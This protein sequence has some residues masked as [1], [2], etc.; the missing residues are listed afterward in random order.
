MFRR[1]QGELTVC[2]EFDKQL[3]IFGA[4]APLHWKNNAART[5]NMRRP[6]PIAGVLAVKDGEPPKV[7][8]YL[9]TRQHIDIDMHQL[10]LSLTHI[11]KFNG[12]Y[13]LHG[14]SNAITRITN[15]ISAVNNKPPVRGTGEGATN[16]FRP[17]R[18]SPRAVLAV[19]A[20]SMY[21]LR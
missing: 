8:L 17:I 10:A 14:I 1:E 13:A 2:S 7:M 3:V 11:R 20:H 19:V 4:G 16:H 9:S 12:Q 18:I 5:P 21:L 15:R 6:G